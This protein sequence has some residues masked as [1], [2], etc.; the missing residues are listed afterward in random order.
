[1]KKMILI[2]LMGLLTGCAS[3]QVRQLDTQIDPKGTTADGGTVGLAGGVAIIQTETA[4]DTELRVQDW[5]NSMAEDS[6]VSE[7]TALKYCRLELADPRLGGSGK[8]TEL[9]AVDNLKPIREIRETFGLSGD[10]LEIVKKED[11]LKRL[12]ASRQYAEALHT[13]IKIV[14]ESNEACSLELVKPRIAAGLPGRPYG[15]MSLDTELSNRAPTSVPKPVSVSSS[16]V[17]QSA[18][19]SS[20]E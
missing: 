11:F 10:K 19:D 20:E 16:G 8:I 6:L 5:K 9:P 1:M 17:S 7:H 3:N 4:A 13:M 18:I 12:A 2:T 15:S 14:S